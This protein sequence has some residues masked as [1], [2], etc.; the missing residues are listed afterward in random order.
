MKH[1][2]N[3]PTQA[4]VPWRIIPVV[5]GLLKRPGKTDI[6]KADSKISKTF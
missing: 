2:C 6:K 1:K 3:T 4:A 5:P